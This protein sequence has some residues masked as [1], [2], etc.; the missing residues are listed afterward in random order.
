VAADPSAAPQIAASQAA[1]DSVTD[2]RL[3]VGFLRDTDIAV[4]GWLP[5]FV[6]TVAALSEARQLAD[7]LG[8][9]YRPLFD[10]LIEAITDI[11]NAMDAISVQLRTPCP[12]PSPDAA[13]G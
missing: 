3:I 11:G 2:L 4:D 10:D 8:E 6:G 9:T 12:V 1:C 5:V 13:E 7:S